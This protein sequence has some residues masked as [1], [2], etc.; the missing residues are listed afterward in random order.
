MPWKLWD[1][2]IGHQEKIPGRRPISCTLND[3][4][5]TEF[6]IFTFDIF[7]DLHRLALATETWISLWNLETYQKTCDLGKSGDIKFSNN[8]DILATGSND[9]KIILWHFESQKGFR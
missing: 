9:S 2:S 6:E 7:Y 8:G 3:C 5:A 1:N 4:L